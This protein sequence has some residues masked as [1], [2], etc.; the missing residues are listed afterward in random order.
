MY[1]QGP[2]GVV[3]RS[4]SAVLA[5]AWLQ[6]LYYVN[7]VALSKDESY[8]LLAETDR[9]RVVK[10]W[11]KGPKVSRPPLVPVLA[12]RQLVYPGFTRVVLSLLLF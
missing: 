1:Y 11:L 12:A 8:L 6:G 9:I 7:G 2:A 5:V 3:D 10:Y 4:M